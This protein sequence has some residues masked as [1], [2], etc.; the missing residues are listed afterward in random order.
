M[1]RYSLD[2]FVNTEHIFIKSQVEQLKYVIQKKF[3]TWDFE[4]YIFIRTI[5][6]DYV[7]KQSSIRVPTETL[8]NN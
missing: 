3:G 2:T 7:Y 4:T 6:K 5:E 8:S 1:R